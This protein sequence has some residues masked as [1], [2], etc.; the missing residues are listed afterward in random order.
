MSMIEDNRE[1]LRSRGN[2]MKLLSSGPLSLQATVSSQYNYGQF[3][4][5]PLEMDACNRP[6]WRKPGRLGATICRRIVT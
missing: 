3:E 5:S 6:G 4:A 2:T 1:A